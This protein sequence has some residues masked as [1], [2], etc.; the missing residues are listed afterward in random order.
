MPLFSIIIPAHNAADYLPQC[1]DSIF[2]QKFTD[3][4]VICID[5]GSTDSTPALLDNYATTHGN[6]KVLH[7]HCSGPATA[8]NQGL[9]TAT[10]DYILFVD[11][12]DRILPDALGSLASV[13][14]GEDIV[15]FS[16]RKYFDST[17]KTEDCT[18][19]PSLN[20]T[21]WQYFNHYR[22]T[23][24]PVHF[25]CIWQR[26][27]RREFLEAN[28]LRF[29]DGL[30]RAEDDLFTTMVMLHARS[31]KTIPDCLY[32]YRVRQGSVTRS[33]NP[34]LDDDSHHVQQMLA[35]TFI[36]MQG[37]DKQII[38]QVLASN[39]INGFNRKGN[40][41]TATEWRQFREV[42]VTPRHRRLYR[43][44]RIHPTLFQ[45]YNKL[46]SSLR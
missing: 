16:T 46:C 33:D 22:L 34:K 11:S 41:L 6:L 2:S 29:V 26:A 12:D 31:V 20:D 23:P 38:Y 18:T 15:G 32:V 45:L 43:L 9:A 4:E 35:D 39:Y 40:A 7:Q 5:D 44:I 25:V 28:H 13:I 19:Q 21:G 8:R 36:P 10:G 30:C 42:C 14:N 27:Y 37:I 17:G 1:L 3:Y 24:S